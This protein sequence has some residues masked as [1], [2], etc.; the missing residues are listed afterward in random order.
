MT[1]SLLASQ[2]AF[3]WPNDVSSA[4]EDFIIASSNEKA[5]RLIDSW[6]QWPVHG[7]LLTGPEGSGKSHLARL[8]QEK[9]HATWLETAD[10]LEAAFSSK[11]GGAFIVELESTESLAETPLFHLINRAILG[12]LFL[13]LTAKPDLSLDSLQLRDLR[14]RLRLLPEVS[15]GAPD[16]ALLRGLLVKHFTDRQIDAAPDVIDYM[17]ARIE[18]S[19][20]GARR[21]VAMLDMLALAEGR[22]LTKAIVARY[23]RRDEGIHA[24]DEPS[25]NFNS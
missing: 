5:F 13:L 19:A 7:V 22:K 16:D 18:R 23:L 4:R 11:P 15:L 24:E 2:L 6:P 10:D 9:S 17:L 1:H 25:L 21:T 14:S 20:A 3:N 8:W 12:E